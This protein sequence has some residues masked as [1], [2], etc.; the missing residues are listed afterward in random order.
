MFEEP[1]FNTLRTKETIGYIASFY[2][3]ILR[4]VTG[5]LILV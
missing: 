1:T 3:Y 5:G 4:D 2:K